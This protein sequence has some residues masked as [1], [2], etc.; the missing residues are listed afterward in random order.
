M[1]V[2]SE[3]GDSD[4]PENP[5]SPAVPDVEEGPVHR[6]LIRA[7]LPRPEG[8]KDARTPPEFTVRQAGGRGGNR[9]GNAQFRGGTNNSR[10][11]QHSGGGQGGNGH[12]PFGG[13]RFAGARSGQGQGQGQGEGRAATSVRSAAASGRRR[14]QA[15]TLAASLSTV[16]SALSVLECPP[17]VSGGNMLRF[18]AL[19]FVVVILFVQGAA[20][21]ENAQVQPDRRQPADRQDPGRD[22]LRCSSRSSSS[23]RGCPDVRGSSPVLRSSRAPKSKRGR[24]R[25]PAT[26]TR[27]PAGRGP[28][29]SGP[30]LIEGA[31]PQRHARRP[32][33]SSC[34]RIAT[35]PCRR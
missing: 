30:F 14:P 25:S 26:T 7:T 16:I 6:P 8:Q 28:A 15:L 24:S 29:R 12:R 21:V 4:G 2:D 11:R 20:Q 17:E 33:P 3:N 10:G 19:P 31:T 34:A 32:D 18:P 9:P 1:D 13:T 22:V 27:R 35:P 23:R 5:E